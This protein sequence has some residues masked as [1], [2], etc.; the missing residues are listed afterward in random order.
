MPFIYNVM[1]SAIEDCRP[2]ESAKL[3]LQLVE[4]IQNAIDKGTFHRFSS[5]RPR[6]ISV[7]YRSQ[8][9]SSGAMQ[10]LVRKGYIRKIPGKGTFIQKPLESRGVWLAT[11]LTENLLDF[12]VEWETGLYKKCF[13]FLPATFATCLLVRVSIR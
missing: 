2:A 6:M 8:Q 3:Y 12:G 9:S 5:Y 4:I 1:R 13:R 11:Q 7:N 10:E